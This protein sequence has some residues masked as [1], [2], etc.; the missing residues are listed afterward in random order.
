MPRRGQQRR[1]VEQRSGAGDPAHPL[2]RPPVEVAHPHRH[3]ESTGDRHGPV[4]GEVAAGAGLGRGRKGK[5]ERGDRPEPG[6]P[7]DGIGEN[8]EQQRRRT[9]AHNPPRVTAA[10]LPLEP[11]HRP[12]DSPI[13][14]GAVAVR[15]LEQGHVAIAQRQAEPVVGRVLAQGA[16]PRAPQG[17]Q[18]LG[19]AQA[20]GELDRGDV[21]RAGERLA[22]PHRAAEAAIVIARRVGAGAGL[23]DRRDVGQD[24]CRGISVVEG[25]TVEER[26]VATM[27]H[28]EKLVE[29]E[30]RYGLHSHV[31]VIEAMHRG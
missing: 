25:D 1:A 17:E 30:L 11:A 6:D 13:G 29:G 12:P 22:R 18:Q 4:V 23:V 2:H 7:G 26:L 31:E 19:G 5:L 9:G 15:E 8:V 3:G 10:L 14:D 16:E 21:E 27:G 28:Q 20:V 24:R